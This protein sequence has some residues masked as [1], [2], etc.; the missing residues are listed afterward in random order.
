MN[1]IDIQPITNTILCFMIHS[2][3]LPGYWHWTLASWEWEQKLPVLSYLQRSSPSSNPVHL[4]LFRWIGMVELPWPKWADRNAMAPICGV[5]TLPLYTQKHT[6]HTVDNCNML[7]IR[8][9]VYGHSH[10]ACSASLAL[11]SVVNLWTWP[12]KQKPCKLL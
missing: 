12:W 10:P 8:M 6:N 3:V 9:F 5:R 1:A 7:L 11:Y 4:T 2:I